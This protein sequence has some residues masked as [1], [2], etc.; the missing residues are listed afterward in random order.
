MYSFFCRSCCKQN[1]MERGIKRSS[2]YHSDYNNKRL[3]LKP[4]KSVRSSLENLANETLIE[5]FEY[6]DINDVYFGFFDLN[7]RFSSLLIYLQIPFQID[8]S[9]ISKSE[10]AHVHSF[11]EI[12]S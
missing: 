12:S 1:I 7:N 6:L 5:V 9:K 10:F 8:L 11:L 4:T 3:K 2:I